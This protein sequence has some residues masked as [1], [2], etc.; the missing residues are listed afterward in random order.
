SS[1]MELENAKRIA[2]T[3]VTITVTIT[4]SAYGCFGRRRALLDLDRV[5][6]CPT[7]D[8]RRDYASIGGAGG[9]GTCP[10]PTER[11]ARRDPG[12]QTARHPHAARTA[13][14]FGR[15]S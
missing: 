11:G 4:V 8:G 13:Q 14:S 10:G 7:D 5:L 15:V 6:N 12:R 3:T 1:L 2:S 9:F